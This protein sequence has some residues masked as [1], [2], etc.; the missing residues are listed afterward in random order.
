MK[1]SCSMKGPVGVA[2]QLTRQK[3]EVCLAGADDLIGLGWFGNH[4]DC[5][6]GSFSLAANG[7]GVVN[8]IAGADGNLLSRAVAAGRDVDEIDV[9]QFKKLGEG[10]GLG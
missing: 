3:D 8:L 2:K 1:N 10:D 4:A 6:S 5:G 7:I 9:C